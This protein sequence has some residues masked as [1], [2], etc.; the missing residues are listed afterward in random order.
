[1]KVSKQKPTA[2]S[3]PARPIRV[4]LIEDNSLD[5]ALV[6]EILAEQ[7]QWPISVVPVQNLAQG[8]AC[9]GTEVF[10]IIL[11]DLSLPDSQGLE[12]LAAIQACSPSL[13]VIVL[14]GHDNPDTAL[15]AIHFGAQDYWVKGHFDW[16]YLSHSLYYA[17][18]RKRL[19]RQLHHMAL[20]DA[21]TH[22]PNRSLLLERLQQALAQKK[23]D[24]QFLLAFFFLD[25]DDFKEV[26]DQYG[27]KTGD[28]LLLQI[29]QRLS[30]CLRPMDT[31]ARLGGDEFCILLTGLSS[32]KDLVL[33]QARIEAQFDTPFEIEALS[34]PISVSLGVI[35]NP[36]ATAKVETILEA[37]DQAMYK[38]KKRTP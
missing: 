9:L 8:Q 10:D 4:L 25:V 5:A 32:E 15:Q 34:L 31:V 36:P 27:H 18:E 23:R 11:L 20:Y 29:G 13:P 12:T 14:T 24:P 37:A 2:Q 17:I 35:F 1:M 19:L 30:Q 21:L 16:E 38:A 7:R 22:L 33:I 3:A 6:T 26:N 28:A